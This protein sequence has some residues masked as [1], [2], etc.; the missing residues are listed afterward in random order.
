MTNDNEFIKDIDAAQRFLTLTGTSEAQKRYVA[1]IANEAKKKILNSSNNDTVIH[2]TGK[3]GFTIKLESSKDDPLTTRDKVINT[4]KRII[5]PVYAD[6]SYVEVQTVNPLNVALQNDNITLRAQVVARNGTITTLTADLATAT[7]NY[8]NAQAEVNRLT[9]DIKNLNKDIT[10]LQNRN[11][12]II[13]GMNNVRAK[14]TTSKQLIK[15]L[16]VDKTN[17]SAALALEQTN[18]TNLQNMLAAEQAKLAAEQ[19]NS[20]A[21]QVQLAAEHADLVAEKKLSTA[22]QAN[23]TAEQAK[24]AA[25][26]AKLVTEQAN[27]AAIQAQLGITNQQL[28]TEQAN[29]AAIQAQLGITNQQL[30]ITNQQLVQS[31]QDLLQSSNIIDQLNEDIRLHNI[32]ITE[33]TELSKQYKL[34]IDNNNISIGRLTNERDKFDADIDVLTRHISQLTNNI[35][36]LNNKH[37]SDLAAIAQSNA[38]AITAIAQ[39]NASIAT[40]Q[41][42]QQQQ[43]DALNL[44]YNQQLSTLSEELKKNTEELSTTREQLNKTS[45]DLITV[46]LTNANLSKLVESLSKE[47]KVLNQ[48]LVELNQIKNDSTIVVNNLT[49]SQ[50]RIAHLQQ[51]LLLVQQEQTTGISKI[52][53]LN[54][55]ILAVQQINDALKL[56][57]TSL[58]TANTSLQTANTSLQT[59]NDQLKH[60][61]DTMKDNHL[62]LVTILETLVNEIA[63]LLHYNYT[64]NTTLTDKLAGIKARLTSNVDNAN[65]SI[66]DI[67]SNL[68]TLLKS[69]ETEYKTNWILSPTV[70]IRNKIITAIDSIINTVIHQANLSSLL[71]TGVNTDIHDLISIMN[72]NVNNVLLTEQLNII[73]ELIQLKTDLPKF[74][75]L[76]LSSRTIDNYNTVVNDMSSEIKN[77][78]KSVIDRIIKIIAPISTT[79]RSTITHVNKLNEEIK[80]LTDNLESSKNTNQ[81]L[82]ENSLNALSPLIRLYKDNSSKMGLDQNTINQFNSQIEL[83][84]KAATPIDKLKLTNDLL[85]NLYESISYSIV[86][87]TRNNAKL[88]KQISDIN[89]VHAEDIKEISDELAKTKSIS[90]QQDRTIAKLLSDI[91]HNTDTIN[92]LNIKIGELGKSSKMNS[93]LAD[94]ND[95]YHEDITIPKL[96]NQ[97]AD[98]TKANR[99]IQ[100]ELD[101]FKSDNSYNKSK[102]NSNELALNKTIKDQ[103]DQI[104]NLHDEL[105]QIEELL[106]A[107]TSENSVEKKELNDSIYK[108]KDELEQAKQSLQNK[109]S[110]IATLTANLNQMRNKNFDS[111]AVIKSRIPVLKHGGGSTSLSLS[112]TAMYSSILLPIYYGIYGLLI[113]LL[114]LIIYYFAN[115]IYNRYISSKYVDVYNINKANTSNL[116]YSY[117]YPLY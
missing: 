93:D 36:D 63:N 59:Q 58:Q 53:E 28:A 65:I 88:T 20:A 104:A 98:L 50:Q 49:A 52:E 43:I 16:T 23:L 47:N 82:I 44:H 38:Q 108:L 7:N 67:R 22:I 78:T 48:S 51:E 31:Q 64:N 80:T 46:N 94:I 97:I 111:S 106:S 29:S 54:K 18:V 101:K 81:L 114:I 115:R 112:F 99:M 56:Q 60:V 69:I 75:N 55:T 103:E 34:D 110:M 96:N 87:L 68:S 11:N 26:Q 45:S 116:S 100:Q 61:I 102:I 57:N 42:N 72:A 90:T 92:Q 19:A 2:P 95:G 15:T 73:Y 32:T 71:P 76:E 89:S 3:N 84:D 74:K 14:L 66:T 109:E 79:D 85:S 33:L 4:V 24:L 41:L 39:A 25:E 77:T 117:S 10:T 86:V 21:I 107:T 27:S 70:E 17:L 91:T 9:N 83:I 13:T 6:A 8:N 62:H 5:T 12:N 1:D 105:I 37:A 40:L 35:A 113:F 30:G